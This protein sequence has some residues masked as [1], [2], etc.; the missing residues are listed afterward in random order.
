ML[1]CLQAIGGCSD[2][3]C[4]AGYFISASIDRTPASH[5]GTLGMSLTSIFLIIVILIRH[6]VLLLHRT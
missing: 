3:G 2:D 6:K 5:V 4:P 1:Y